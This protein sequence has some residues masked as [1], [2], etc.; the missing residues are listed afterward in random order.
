MADVNRTRLFRKRRVREY[1]GRGAIYGWL[2][3][4]HAEVRLRREIEQRPWASIIPEIIDD[5]VRRDDGLEPTA[6]NVARIWERV[7]RDV[8]AQAASDK[9]KR[10]FPSRI[11]PDWR[12]EIVPPPP[13]IRPAPYP[14]ATGPASARLG[15]QATSDDDDMTP[16]AR[17]V[18][19]RARAQLAELDRKKFRF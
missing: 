4:H 12:P 15:Q 9:P 17:A 11:S 14:A 10:K 8:E 18:L 19:D 1:N 2:R 16:E 7:C 5:G 13:P 6:K 3:T